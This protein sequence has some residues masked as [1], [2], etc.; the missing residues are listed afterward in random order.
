MPTA[1]SRTAIRSVEALPE[2]A[3][4]APRSG[5]RRRGAWGGHE[6]ARVLLVSRPCNFL[7]PAAFAVR[8]RFAAQG[9]ALLDDHGDNL[10]AAASFPCLFLSR[11]HHSICLRGA[12]L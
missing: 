4:Q 9:E 5:S 2:P 10:V 7:Q 6:V 11:T 12:Y 3:R 8:L 1:I